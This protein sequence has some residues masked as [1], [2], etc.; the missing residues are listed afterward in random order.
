MVKWV[1]IMAAAAVG[2]FLAGSARPEAAPSSNPDDVL[3]L[4]SPRGAITLVRGLPDGE[5]VRIPR[6]VPS[7]DWSTLVQAIPGGAETRVVALD[8]RSGSEVWARDVPGKLTAEIASADGRL[9]ALR[10][11]GSVAGYSS[12]TTSTTFVIAGADVEPRTIELHGNFQAEAFSTDGDSLF[13]V[14]YLPP[15]NPTSYRV[16][17]LDLLTGTVGGVYSVDAHLQEA[18]Q[19]TA[20]VQ[21]ASPDGDRLYTLYT[22]RDVDGGRHAF[23]HVLSLDEEWAHCIDLPPSFAVGGERSIAL[24]V[25]PD[26]NRLYVAD[27]STGSVAEVDTASLAA[28]RTA[29][30]PFGTDQGMGHAVTGPDG[31]VYLGK[32][33]E[34]VAVDGST[35]TPLASWSMEQRITGLQVGS[36][37]N[38]LYVGLR[39]EIVILDPEAGTTVGAL[40]PSAIGIIDQL[41]ESTRRLDEQRTD[42]QCAC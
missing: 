13:V 7:T 5:A 20:R 15:R 1:A 9:V 31:T 23:V 35:L 10:P 37:P 19:G 2:V 27:A 24:A 6:A 18:M 38:Q 29:S 40:D 28:A 34:L 21:A 4:R 42:I 8:P 12:G 17:R 25:A 26:G 41:G 33:S 14:E 30:L 16:R 22:L 39:D 36:G 3:F 32:G 11:R